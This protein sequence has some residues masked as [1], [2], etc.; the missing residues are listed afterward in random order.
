LDYQS[1]HLRPKASFQVYTHKH[2]KPIAKIKGSIEKPEL[3]SELK[4][5][6][7]S[8]SLEEKIKKGGISF[9]VDGNLDIKKPTVGKPKLSSELNTSVLDAD[10]KKIKILPT[11]KKAKAS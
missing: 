5:D 8:I 10:K 9:E 7:Q 2:S 1:N 4:I 3:D 6:K 11:I